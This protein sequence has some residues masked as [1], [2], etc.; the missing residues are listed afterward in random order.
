[1]KHFVYIAAAFTAFVFAPAAFAAQELTPAQVE[2]FIGTMDDV[3]A[4]SDSMGKDGK[5]QVISEKLKEAQPG[6]DFTPY[7]RAMDV[8]K[9]EFP[10][11]YKKLGAAVKKQ[12]FASQQEWAETG[13]KVMAAYISSRIDP[14][15][16]TRMAAMKDQLNTDA[17][18]QMPPEAVA[19]IKQTMAMME[20]LDKVPQADRD[21]IAPH[22]AALEAF[23]Q[24]QSAA[25]QEPAAG[26]AAP[27]P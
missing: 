2:K 7:S 21:A 13:D 15:T 16:K 1:M 5:N 6:G 14:E 18:K 19:Q 22:S 3:Q 10:D 24:S 23:V 25:G 12:G 27:A 9:A 20:T 11:D 4:L 17:A 26:A 8:M